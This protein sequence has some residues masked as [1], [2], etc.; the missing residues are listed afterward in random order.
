MDHSI[1]EALQKQIQLLSERSKETRI[2]PVDLARLTDSMVEAAKF[3]SEF[4]LC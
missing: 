2:E 3:I 4:P 1:K